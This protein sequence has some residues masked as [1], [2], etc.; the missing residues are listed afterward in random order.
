MLSSMFDFAHKHGD[1]AARPHE[2]MAELSTP[3]GAFLDA[4]EVLREYPRPQ[5]RRES[6]VNLNGLWDYA[7]VAREGGGSAVDMLRAEPSALEPPDSYQGR[8]LVPFSPEAPLSGVRR[9]LGPDEFLW[10]RRDIGVRPGDDTRVLLHFEA[11]DSTCACFVNGMLAGVHEG[12]Y[13]PFSYDI[14]AAL[15]QGA[16]ELVVCVADPS[17][18]RPQP[19]GKQ[20]L[21]R[22]SIWYT[23]QSG[24]WQTVWIEVVPE[25][26]VTS[27]HV[28]ADLDRERL[29]VTASVS[30]GGHE[31]SVAV[32][33]G[34]G[35]SARGRRAVSEAGTGA[36]VVIDVPSPRPWSP[37]DPFLYRVRL[38][39][40]T[41]EVES[42]CAFRAF[43][44][45][46][47]GRGVRR[48]CLNHRPIFLKG[49]LDQGYWPDGLMTPPSDEALRFDIEMARELGFNMM[50]KHIKV[51]SE[52]WYYHCDRLGMIVWQDMVNGGGHYHMSRLSHFPT[53]LPLLGPLVS[54]SRRLTRFGSESEEYRHLWPGHSL[55]IVEHLRDHP[56]IAT[57]TIFNEGWGQFD[58]RRM[59]QAVREAD[60]SRPLD[61]ASGWFYQ[62]KGDFWSIHNY[63]RRL[64]M[65]LG[66]RVHASVITEFGGL[67]LHVDGHSAFDRVFGYATVGTPEELRSALGDLF[68]KADSLERKG[69]SGYV[70]TQLSDV[71]EEVNGL[72]TYDRRCVKT[73]VGKAPEQNR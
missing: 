47:D 12:G 3:W 6:Y 14:T 22:G 71:E 68:A 41:D 63:F 42:Y 5:M 53:L 9:Q 13:L 15:E 17:E 4:D 35:L 69:L 11:V 34:A 30:A 31:L 27:L 51:E 39:Y 25:A 72:L 40:G 59:T 64:R 20:M 61:Q 45:E 54:D 55:A 66:K 57:W 2:P 44:V 73:K 65:P 48:F 24:I 62:G 58:A 49:I 29:R 37:N 67:T 43:S 46:R 33:D 7:F 19:R 28:E 21:D 18:T 50:R 52:R 60:P 32:S 26:H 16:G 70:Y 1:A 8:I 23:A 10:Y 36:E 38:T 56:C